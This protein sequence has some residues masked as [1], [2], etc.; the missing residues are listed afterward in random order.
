MQAV[1][2]GVVDK[3]ERPID[4][5]IMAPIRERHRKRWLR[6]RAWRKAKAQSAAILAKPVTS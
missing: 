6:Q 5:T 3:I 2:F 4:A 1:I